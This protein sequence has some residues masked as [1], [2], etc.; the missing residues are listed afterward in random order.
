[1]KSPLAPP[2]IELPASAESL[3]PTR[4]EAVTSGLPSCMLM[5]SAPSLPNTTGAV[6]KPENWWY[7]SLPRPRNAVSLPSVAA[8]VSL[9]SLPKN[10]C[11]PVPPLLNVV[12]RSLPNPATMVSLPPP[13]KPMPSRTVSAPPLPNTRSAPPPGS[14]ESLP[15]LESLPPTSVCAAVENAGA[16]VSAPSPPSSSD[17]A[18]VVGGNDRVVFRAAVDGAG[19]AGP[20]GHGVVARIPGDGGEAAAGEDA[21]VA[22]EP[23]NGAGAGVGRLVQHVVAGGAGRH[24][25]HGDLP[26]SVVMRR[27]LPRRPPERSSV[28]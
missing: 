17:R 20:Q 25:G 7:E 22:G 19:I 10:S 6:G 24:I 18:D 1:M 28:R 13:M 9:P 14:M 27:R 4:V 12:M 2:T 15:S 8:I 23:D 3:P 5:V 16:I 21:V 26:W 11:A